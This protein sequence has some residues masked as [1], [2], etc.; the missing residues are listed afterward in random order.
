MERDLGLLSG[1]LQD[2]LLVPLKQ[3]KQSLYIILTCC[4][5]VCFGWLSSYITTTKL[6][7]TSDFPL[8]H[9]KMELRGIVLANENKAIQVLKPTT[10][11]VE[12]KHYQ[13]SYFLAKLNLIVSTNCY[14]NMVP[15]TDKH[16]R[17]FSSPNP[18]YRN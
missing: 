10:F 6:F 17:Q 1:D 12:I 16:L 18:G 15:Y 14:N 11:T 8:P 13:V 4:S 3:K 7:F 2:Q 9:F 5:V